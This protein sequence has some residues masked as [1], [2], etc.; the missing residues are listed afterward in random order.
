MLLSDKV[1]IVYG[2]AGSVGSAVA[3]AFARAG[4]TVVLAGR[5]LATLEPVAAA[6]AAD[7]G[8]AECATVDA[9]D[10][11]AVDAH[12]D[13]VGARHGR[14]DIA[15][16]AIGLGDTQGQ[17]LADMRPDRFFA[18]IDTAMKAQLFTALAVARH[19]KGSGVILAITAN[20]GR[21]P[22]PNVGG[23]G[24]ACA[25][26]EGLSRQLATE[27]GPR[28]IR[29]ICLMSAGSPDSRGVSEVFDLHAK[30]AGISRAEWDRQAGLGTMLRHLPSL[31]EIADAAVLM[32]SDKARGMTA[33]IVNLTCGQ[34]AD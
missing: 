34:L 33:T 10:Q 20:C 31:A 7:G 25:A 19:M 1:A 24:V 23:F 21:Q 22:F 9:V 32:A 12:T 2:A 27:L 3:R 29:V 13:A 16:N 4:A 8:R 11:R 15:F 5:T 30:N 17:P 6:I 26:I 14:I 18:P 28:G